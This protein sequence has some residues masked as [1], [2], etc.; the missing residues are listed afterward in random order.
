MHPPCLRHRSLLKI[1]S[2]LFQVRRSTLPYPC[3]FP[4]ACKMCIPLPLISIIDIS[5]SH[6]D[7]TYKSELLVNFFFYWLDCLATGH[8]NDLRR[9]LVH[10]FICETQ[11]MS[12]CQYEPSPMQ[13]INHCQKFYLSFF[14]YEDSWFKILFAL[15]Y[16]LHDF[17]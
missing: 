15:T 9:I 11:N 5:L 3:S 14:K 12:L 10:F 2:W 4:P 16:F 13:M 1:W 17:Q 6:F 8:G 7:F